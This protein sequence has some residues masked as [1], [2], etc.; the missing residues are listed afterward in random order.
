MVA[1]MAREEAVNERDIAQAAEMTA[2]AA[3]AAAE[4][5]RDAAVAAQIAADIAR[6]AAEGARDD[7]QAQRDAA[8]TAQTAAEA[9]R[10][11]AMAAQTAAETARDAAVAA[12]IAADIARVAAEGARD[13]AQAQRDAAMTAQTAA[14]A[15]R[16][17]AMAAQTAAETARDAARSERDDARIQLAVAQSALDTA[18]DDLAQARTDATLDAI[19]IARLGGEVTRLEGEVEDLEGDVAQLN[20]DL[21]AA[22][23]QL[24][25]LRERQSEGNLTASKV[26]A[27][28]SVQLNDAGELV[29]EGDVAD[30]A[31]FGRVNATLTVSHDRGASRVV[32]VDDDMDADNGTRYASYDAP[33]SLG[34][35]WHGNSFDM[36]VA[37]G[38]HRIAFIYTDIEAPARENFRD[39]YG[40]LMTNNRRDYQTTTVDIEDDMGEVTEMD[41]EVYVD[42][43]G[44]PILDADDNPVRTTADAPEGAV[45][46]VGG[47]LLSTDFDGRPKAGHPDTNATLLTNVTD[48]DADADPADLWVA[49]A[50]ESATEFW[51]LVRYTQSH[52]RSYC[53][54]DL[55]DATNVGCAEAGG[56]IGYFDGVRGQFQCAQGAQCVIII[57]GT[58]SDPLLAS[59]HL[60]EFVPDS[61]TANVNTT[62]LDGD[63]LTMGWWIQKP[64]R[65]IGTYMF[66]RFVEGADPYTGTLASG[67]DAGSATYMGPAAGMWAERVRE[68]EEAEFGTFRAKATLT[69]DFVNT[70]VSGRID[71]FEL[72]NGDSRSWIVDLDMTG[73]TNDGGDDAVTSGSADGRDWA[74]EWSYDLYGNRA[75]PDRQE[76]RPTYIAGAF[77]AEQGTPEI[78]PEDQTGQGQ[79][80]REGDEGF[81]GVSGVYGAK[82]QQ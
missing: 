52:A 61:V 46:G 45:P 55:T 50:A 21:T 17:A 53:G 44:D 34:T 7:A 49:T 1:E 37:G 69:A 11:A 36:T 3:Q 40:N 59:A 9:A 2:M 39:A 63:Y 26:A 35:G 47:Y 75:A 27:V 80:L 62:R 64:D 54:T 65:A 71:D 12:Q 48:G 79:P 13:D 82:L 30:T 33:M 4:T 76:N 66:S 56:F 42:A 20:M 6:V 18:R 51:S 43:D 38:A 41:V 81:V 5:A 67:T 23:L 24:A 70:M 60:W 57:A 8:M 28:I 32:N 16:D 78:G 10:D 58:I 73:L 29:E 68:L 19:E 74:G 22:E 31:E 72:S 25:E 77:R 14:E 15:A